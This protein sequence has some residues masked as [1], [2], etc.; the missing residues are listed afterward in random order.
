VNRFVIRFVVVFLMSVS[1]ASAQTTTGRIIG[2]VVD[3]EGGALSG[4]NVTIGSPALIGGPQTRV[5]DNK[6][7]FSFVGIA[8]GEYTVN[9]EHSG[10]IPQERT[11]VKVSLGQAVSLTITMPKGVFS[12]EIE[13]FD[14]TPVVDPTQVNT[15]QVF[16]QSYMQNSAIGSFNRNYLVVVNQTAGVSG[17]EA[18]EGIPQPRVFGST[19]G[20]NAYF[21]DGM[22][23]TDPVMATATFTMNFDAIGE[24]QFQTGGFE[25]EYG[26]ATGGILNLVTK[27]GGNQFSGTLDIRYRND[28][29]QESGEYFD[30]SQLDSSFQQ[31]SFTFGGPIL[32][33]RMWF[34]ASYEWMQA[35]FTPIESPTTREEKRQNYL[36]KITWQ[37]DPSW[38]LTGK[39]SSAPSRR[40]NEYASRWRMLE[41]TAFAKDETTVFSAELSSVL[42][43]SLLWNTTLGRYD[44]ELHRFPQTGDLQAIGHE[45]YDTGL[46]THNYETQQYWGS[47]RQDLTTDL[48]WFVKNLAGSHEFK[49]GIEYSGIALPD[50]GLCFTGTPNGEQCVEGV[51]GFY[52]YDIESGTT[53]PYFMLESY[54][55]TKT[56]YNGAVSTAFVQDAWQ[57]TSNL[58][59]KIGLRFDT[60]TYDDNEGAEIADMGML[61]PRLG[62][63]WDLTGNAKNLFRASWGRFM[64]PNALTLSTFATTQETALSYWYSCS[65]AVPQILGIS[66]SSAEECA[67]AAVDLGYP[68]RLDNE[69]WDPF[70]WMLPPWES[71]GLFSGQV[72][73]NLRAT[74]A[75][76]LILAFEREVGTRSSIEFTFVDKKTRDIFDNTCNGNIPTPSAD[77]ECD[78]YV[79]ANIPGLLRDFRG[80]TARF[81]TRGLQWLTLLASYSYS[82]SEG[83]VEYAQNVDT[84]ADVYPWHFNNRYGYLSDH[85]RHRLK[86]NG[87]IDLK[88]DWTIAF[89]GFWSSPFTWAPFENP[90]DNPEIPYGTHF[91]EPR[92]SR[93]ANSQH[94]LDL[95]LS[96]GFTAGRTRFVLIGTVF[97]ALSSEQPTAVC[98]H[99]S[100]CGVDENENPIDMGDSTNW[101]TPRRFEVGFRVEF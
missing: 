16:D 31:Y 20:E 2:T 100:G 88:G 34:F 97:N 3:D 41:A 29:F 101:Q 89:D 7:E 69:G 35:G 1:G 11:S 24:I 17:G 76:E 79:M 32:S 6:G 85:R 70:G 62:V 82:T 99:I 61:Q 91:L 94:Q 59:L 84:V 39:Y 53:L 98:S 74:Y 75:D 68:Y 10:F 8:P 58:T 81:E 13:V 55:F 90:S 65:G 77:A 73:P 21:I 36:A 64:H 56:E 86:L 30:A 28:T 92:G 26:R 25:A 47:I 5:T 96:K 14:E 22:D 38:R 19:I 67:A 4:I 43:D 51:P 54:L 37:I 87:F 23:T 15:G 63:A 45:N 50:E 44:Y 95:Q 9:A 93:E 66:V 48:T 12:G 72:A 33:D 60:V 27:S 49:G 40:E 52:F 42:S 80:F 71:F 57:P 83:S 78:Y 18:W 46:F